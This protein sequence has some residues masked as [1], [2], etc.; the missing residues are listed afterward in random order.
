[1]ALRSIFLVRL[2]QKFQSEDI[3]RKRYLKWCEKNA[4]I[5]AISDGGLSFKVTLFLVI[6]LIAVCCL[7]YLSQTNCVIVIA[8]LVLPFQT[9]DFYA[10][11]PP[12]KLLLEIM[13]AMASMLLILFTSWSPSIPFW[14]KEVAFPLLLLTNTFSPLSP[15]GRPRSSAPRPTSLQR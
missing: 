11:F 3:S 2:F 4:K 10:V 15:S 5:Y 6:V 14:A 12:L 8:L 13:S 7:S 1:M 9:A